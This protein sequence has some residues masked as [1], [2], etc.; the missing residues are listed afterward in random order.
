MLPK[1]LRRVSLC[2]GLD[3]NAVRLVC[4]PNTAIVNT[5]P[6]VSLMHEPESQEPRQDLESRGREFQLPSLEPHLS[7]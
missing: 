1:V 6:M 2:G 5:N 3:A 4:V 7:K